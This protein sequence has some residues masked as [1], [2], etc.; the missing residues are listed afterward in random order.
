MMFTNSLEEMPKFTTK[1][2]CEAASTKEIPLVWGIPYVSEDIDALEMDPDTLKPKESCLVKLPEPDCQKASHSRTNHLG[3]GVNAV[4]LNYT[5][6]LP[7]FQSGLE[8]RCVLRIRYNISTMDYDR[9]NTFRDQ[10]GD[11]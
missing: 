7:Y 3:N 9:D 1:K 11:K 4:P 2:S 5:W 6:V 10:N 8:Q